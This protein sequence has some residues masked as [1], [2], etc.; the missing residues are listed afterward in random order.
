MRRFILTAI[1]TFGLTAGPSASA[2]NVIRLSNAQSRW[3]SARSIRPMSERAVIFGTLP[4]VGSVRFVRFR[5][6]SNRSIR[7][8]VAVPSD[9]AAGFRPQLV[10]SQPSGMPAAPVLPFASPP[11]TVNLAFGQTARTEVT[12]SLAGISY[13]RVFSTSLTAESDAEWY[14]AVYNAGTASG[15]FRLDIASGQSFGRW[16]TYPRYWFVATAWAGPTA[17]SWIWPALGV[18]A[19]GGLAWVGWWLGRRLTRATRRKKS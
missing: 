14:A 9:A 3:E 18:V 13:H 8:D 17:R 2:I 5:V 7:F 11:D 4:E 6:S 16:W 19:I 10:V 12:E 15:S 1:V